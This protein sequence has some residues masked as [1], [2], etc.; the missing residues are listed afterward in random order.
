MNVF[1][2]ISI[3]PDNESDSIYLKLQ[4]VAKRYYC[5]ESKDRNIDHTSFVALFQGLNPSFRDLLQHDA[6]EFLY[7]LIDSID[8]DF[9][10]CDVQ[11]NIVIMSDAESF[12]PKLFE[13]K[14]E[15]RSCCPNC[16]SRCQSQDLFH[17]LLLK[18]NSKI[19][20][21]QD[22]LEQFTAIEHLDTHRCDECN[23]MSNKMKQMVITEPPSN[24]IMSLKLFFNAIGSGGNKVQRKIEFDTTFH[25]RYSDGIA[26][27][28]LLAFTV[29]LG[30]FGSG[31]YIALI[32]DN[33]K[34][35]KIQ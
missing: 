27:Y 21:V 11:R 2:N 9:K 8:E 14:M 19:N 17:I 16:L 29:H 3:H 4:Y 1:N 30:A 13:G 7:A 6:T 28:K 10:K 31:H 23:E 25:L 18:I 33:G 15:S 5:I 32:Y 12:L 20:S 26:E 34:W 24:L 22:A 35:F